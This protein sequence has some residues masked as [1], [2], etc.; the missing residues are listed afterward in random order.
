MV[1]VNERAVLM[2]VWKFLRV[3]CQTLCQ[4]Y[5][6]WGWGL[7][8]G[9]IY[10]YSHAR[11]KGPQIVY[12]APV[13]RWHVYT[14]IVAG[15]E[16]GPC[17]SPRQP[18]RFKYSNLVFLLW[19]ME[20]FT[21]Q[22]GH[23]FPQQ[24]AWPTFSPPSNHSVTLQKAPGQRAGGRAVPQNLIGGLQRASFTCPKARPGSKKN[25]CNFLWPTPTVF[26]IALRSNDNTDIYVLEDAPCGP[27]YIRTPILGCN[28]GLGIGGIHVN[29]SIVDKG[30][31]LK[32]VAYKSEGQSI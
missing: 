2:C 8:Q 17:I 27:G 23:V 16:T 31:R 24:A 29:S 11:P 12:R 15:L 4:K 19:L 3:K 13:M 21:L 10:I 5:T 9:L 1:R 28:K 20:C 18:P 32:N 26:L 25:P 22:R 7:A 14:N 6:H 30:L